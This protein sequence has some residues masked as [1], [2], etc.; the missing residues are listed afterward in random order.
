M[1]FF[2]HGIINI[3]SFHYAASGNDEKEGEF[4]ISY[5]KKVYESIFDYDA[6][7]ITYACRAG[8]SVEGNDF[9]GGEYAGQ[10]ESPAQ[11]MA[12]TWDVNVKAFEMR[13]LYASVYGTPEELAQVKKEQKIV[14]KYRTELARYNIGE[15]TGNNRVPKP[16]KPDGYDEMERRVYEVHRR[17]A[18]SIDGGGPIAPNGS[19]CFPTTASSPTGLRRG[20][21][22]YKPRE[23]KVS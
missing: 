19:W 7:V 22:P 2:C 1:V 15:L 17:Q 14:E 5:I 10:L 21:L 11:K 4:D 6:E 16:K 20:L 12:D 13:S 9:S 18:N 8:I 23:W 3:A